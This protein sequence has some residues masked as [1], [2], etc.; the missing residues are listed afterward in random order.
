MALKVL[1]SLADH[2]GGSLERVLKD[3]WG[4]FQ[5]RDDVLASDGEGGSEG[6]SASGAWSASLIAHALEPT[7]Q[8]SG[9]RVDARMAVAGSTGQV[10]PSSGPRGC[11]VESAPKAGGAGRVHLRR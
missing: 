2:E 11:P 7:S 3:F 4:N 9:F 8:A 6:L 10:R 5:F 1:Y